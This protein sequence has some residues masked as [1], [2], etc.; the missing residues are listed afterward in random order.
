MAR[1]IAD[2][3]V[4][5]RQM[6]IALFVSVGFTRAGGDP[7]PLQLKNLLFHEPRCPF[8]RNDSVFD[9]ASPAGK[10]TADSLNRR[11][12]IVTDANLLTA[13][14][15]TRAFALDEDV[16]P[17]TQYKNEM[18]WLN[19]GRNITRTRSGRWFCCFTSDT[20]Y[21][22]NRWL[23]LCVGEGVHGGDFSEPI[24]L[25]GQ[26]DRWH[27]SVFEDEKSDIGQSCVLLDRNERLHV[28]F[29]DPKG[30]HHLSVE[31][32]AKDLSNPTAWS[33]IQQ[34]VGPGNRL[35]DALLDGAGRC[36]IYH[37]LDG[38]LHRTIVGG[39]TT[40][41]SENAEHPSVHLDNAG[42][43]H[44]AFERMRQI[45]YQREG[46]KPELVAHFCSSWPSIA[47]T[48]DGKVI[49]VYQ[50]EGNA[51]LKRYPQLYSTLR[52]AGGSTISYA[53]HDGKR[54]RL[55]DL[56]RSS[57][58]IL[59]RRPHHRHPQVDP[60]FVPAMEE[61]W[62]PS[63]SI[64]RNGS[65]WMF[66]VNTTRRHIYWSRFQGESFGEHHEA[67]GA[68]DCMS[69]SL[70]LMKDARQSGAIGFMNAACNRMYFD[71]IP[72]PSIDPGRVVMLDQLESEHIIG[73]EQ[74][75]G[76]W[77]KHP[78]PVFGWQISGEDID[79]HILWA[80]VY[81]AEGGLMMHYMTNGPELRCNALPGRAFSADG[82]HWEKRKPELT[83]YWTLDGA[84]MPN[85]FWRP[86]YMEDPTEPDPGQRFKG[87]YA[88]WTPV[89]RI[90]HRMYRVVV[91]ADGKNWR[92]RNDLDPVVQ[93]DISVP[94]HLIRD[95]NDPDPHRRY[96]FITC[97]GS[98]PGRGVVSWTSP[99]LLHWNHIVYMRE[100]PDE[101][102]SAV[103]PY[104]TGPLPLDPDAGEHPWEEEIHDA[105]Q[106]RE[107]G[108]LM[109]HYDSFYFG[110]NQHVEKALGV[111]RDGRHY[112]RV[113]RGRINL[114]HGACGSWD[115]G[116][117]RTS[118]PV[119]VGDELRM[120][121][122]GMPASYFDNPDA[123]DYKP[124]L[125]ADAWSVNSKDWAL[126]LRP[127]R[128]GF[129]RM[130]VDGW[131]Y[132]Q[133]AREAESGE[134]VTIPFDFAGGAMTVNGVGLGNGLQVGW[135]SAD[136]RQPIAGF[137]SADCRFSSGD[138]VD[139]GASWTGGTGPKPGRYRLQFKFN[140]LRAKLFAYGWGAR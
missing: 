94:E 14:A 125:W 95:D 139:A 76:M 29:D 47:T 128:V 60:K 61:F 127:W 7:S 33:P 50:G 72:T 136:G 51:D 12:V 64:D 16:L 114:P 34:V 83:G 118:V 36:V 100:N 70:W 129:A 109:Y 5:K 99:D 45:Y 63:L 84:P 86:L 13:S 131:A 101:L 37:T 56:L 2:R 105:Y 15:H 62:R 66:F 124:P 91:S 88:M 71:S 21:P 57:E 35:G 120:Y 25:V 40:L 74:Q 122:C 44:V 17:G 138:A 134:M 85:A 1:P 73:L 18:P 111:S 53:V 106:W 80:Q 104:A 79:S 97:H 98:Q 41:V 6:L 82:I 75:L 117:V 68:Y 59:K 67:R 93:G 32:S 115:S 121:F 140:D 43:E 38:N 116:R 28:F 123:P 102:R 103:C 49:I 110:A 52:E 113:K 4:K 54:W 133:M 126:L 89:D 92:M 23:L 78:D 135:L 48:Y 58:I 24:R 108:L 137:A 130:R 22:I 39:A 46:G 90:E 77:E 87:L 26:A 27:H 31:A 69:R 8:R 107:H 42:V 132:M 96:K 10:M 19:H 112:W 65:I 20:E 119:R 55:H 9:P 3:L 11:V 30:V 81:R